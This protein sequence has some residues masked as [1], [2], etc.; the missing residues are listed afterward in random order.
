M[1]EE[2]ILEPIDASEWISNMVIGPKAAG[3]VRI[4][5]KLVDVNKPIIA[6]C[7][8]LSTIDDFGSVFNGAQYFSK[9]DVQG[10]YLLV[11]LHR[12]RR[13]MMVLA[14]SS[15]AVDEV[16]DR[17][18]SAPSCFQNIQTQVLKGCECTAHLI[19][20]IIECG[21]TVVEHHTHL[22]AGVDTLTYA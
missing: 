4:C 14:S 20:D 7:Y 16:T 15:S 18:C 21:R 22:R 9:L 3:G 11:S 19:N 2:G 1:L 13:H 10:V 8:P 6:V 17:L 12:M 5:C